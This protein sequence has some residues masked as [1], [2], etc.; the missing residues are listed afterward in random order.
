MSASLKMAHCASEAIVVSFVGPPESFA[1]ELQ[2]SHPPLA[3]CA[4]P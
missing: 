2:E 3:A 1:R 4:H